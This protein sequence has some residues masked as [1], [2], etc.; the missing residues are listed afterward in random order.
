MKPNKGDMRSDGRKYDGYVWREIGINHH[1]NEKGHVFYKN[2]Y[3][4]VESYL[5]QGGKLE[6][7]VPYIKS[8]LMQIHMATEQMYNEIESGEVYANV[9]PAYQGWVKIGKAVDADNRCADYQTYTPYR[10]CYVLCK[11]PAE[12]RAKREQYMLKLFEQHADER[13]NE[14]FKISIETTLRLFDEERRKENAEK[15]NQD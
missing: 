4:T 12:N 6:R 2:E 15:E 14:W 13:R 10:N 7:I 3:R 8:K 5:R 11:L 9:N 1:A